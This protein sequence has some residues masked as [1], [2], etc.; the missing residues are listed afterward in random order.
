MRRGAHPKK[1]GD[2]TYQ[3][4]GFVAMTLC[5]TFALSIESQNSINTR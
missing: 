4:V 1:H 5:C 3:Q 2:V